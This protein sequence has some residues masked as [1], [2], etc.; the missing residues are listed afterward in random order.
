M[1]NREFEAWWYEGAGIYRHVWMIKTAPVCLDTWGI[2]INAHERENG[3][4]KVDVQADIRS[5]LY[6]TSNISLK[7]QL[8]DKDGNC[9]SETTMHL[10]AQAR[11]ATTATTQMSVTKPHLWSIDQPNLYTMRA[12]LS[13]NGKEIDQVDTSFGFRTLNFTPEGLLLNGNPLKLKG[14][15]AHE[16]HANL[17][18]AVPDDVREYRMR[19]LK[20]IGCNAYR[21]SH[22]PPTPE[23]LDLCDR[24]G[25]LVMD[26]N[27]WF[28]SS[29][30]GLKQLT[31]MI[32]RDRN[33]PSVIIWSMAN[34]EPLQ[35][36]ERGQAIMRSMRFTAR[37]LD[38]TRPIMMAMHSGCTEE[39][40]AAGVSDIIGINYQMELFDEIHA[41]FPGIPLVSSEIGG[42]MLPFGIMGDG[43]GED[44]EA[45]NTRPF[46]LGMFKWAA[47]GYRGESRGW[48]RLFS[49]SGIIEPTGELKE[50]S[51][52]YKQMWDDTEK[53]VKIWPSHWNWEGKEGE[54]IEVKVYTNADEAE[55]S[56]NGKRLGRQ[57]INPYRRTT[58]C[59]PYEPGELTATAYTDGKEADSETI[60]TTSPA[61]AIGLSSSKSH[62]RANR[63]DVVIVNAFSTDQSG[64]RARWAEPEIHFQ[65]DGPARVL[66]VSNDDPYNA[67]GAK[68]LT[69]RMYHGTCQLILCSSTEAG[70]IRITADSESLKS[71]QICVE[72]LPCQR[73]LHVE[74]Q[75]ETD[76]MCYFAKM[77]GP[78]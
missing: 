28:D 27:R 73:P 65:V 71:A 57:K 50:N 48:P 24:L 31:S 42:K 63:T 74:L 4:W 78:N 62:V 40:G 64:K 52:F 55:L 37:K 75:T 51:W 54:L 5:I 70:E 26:E 19:L 53:F 34:E 22:N 13:K 11:T 9:C 30:E 49:R 29:E 45:V 66:A 56:L 12:I 46:M 20:S 32:K 68:E 17:G 16:D 41:K 15:C 3:L 39:N 36:T 77:D 67:A 18:V 25:I 59:I 72:S 44:W 60:S 43:S 8:L 35:G 58:F 10:T 23:V 14:V 69:C 38:D 2:Y 47:F 33:H 7:M 1:D 61:F 21:C 76:A 6:S